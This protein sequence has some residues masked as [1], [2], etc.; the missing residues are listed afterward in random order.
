MISVSEAFAILENL[1]FSLH[2]K[3]ISLW[4]ARNHVLVETV[5]SPISMP[6]FRQSN[7]DGFA[8]AIHDSTEY[9]IIGEIKAGDGNSIA[10]QPGEG[11]KIFTGAAVPN[12]A[13]AVIQIEKVEINGIRLSLQETIAPQTNVRPAGS[14]IVEG[15]TAL[16]KGTLL[17]SAAIGFLA[18]L[19]FSSVTVYQKPTI[20]IIITGNELVEPGQPLPFGKVYESNSVMLRSA[21]QESHFD[22]VTTYAVNDN[23]ESTKEVIA[24][25]LKAHEVILVSGGISVGDY[26]F[27]HTALQDLGVETLFYKVSQ[28]PGKPLYAGKLAEK[29]IFALPGNPAASLTCLYVHV[30]PTLRRLSG[31]MAS[32]HPKSEKSLTHDYEVSNERAQF[33]KAR[34][35]QDTVTILPHQ[36]SS[37]LD[38]FALANALVYLPQGKYQKA[39][40]D[41]VAVYII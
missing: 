18:G 21:L 9:T 11:V 39:K 40:G 37:M 26:D 12:S 17:N 33:L 2:P 3:T 27:V 31:I 25:A 5:F 29:I 32:Y 4:E 8:I 14:Q 36:D 7:M 15:E 34:I 20:G 1:S 13:Q 41:M 23:L 19:G 30:L 35:F 38:S 24:R 22:D 6:P 10:L 16:E 28:K